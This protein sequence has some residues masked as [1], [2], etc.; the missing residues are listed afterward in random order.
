[1]AAQAVIGGV[2]RPAR[3]LRDLPERRRLDAVARAEEVE[4][5]PHV[6][7]GLGDEPDVAV[8]VLRERLRQNLHR[9]SQGRGPARARRAG[10]G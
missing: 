10:E 5:V 9:H 6:V 7:R 2:R 8:A 3:A 4:H 1:M